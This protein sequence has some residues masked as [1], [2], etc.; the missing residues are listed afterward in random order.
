MSNV[1]VK[2]AK[3]GLGLFAA[4]LIPSKAEIIEYVGKIIPME[5]AMS[6]SGKYF[7]D[8]DN[9]FAIDG[10]SRKN[11]ARYINHSCKPNAEAII[12]DERIW[13]WSRKTIRTGEEITIDYG[14]E[15]FNEFIKPKGCK[16]EKCADN[17]NT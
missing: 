2:R 12:I 10:R 4:K 1:I 3:T 9:G 14:E 15:Y 6:S 7:F 5:E 11:L 8:L 17:G 13:I 16:C